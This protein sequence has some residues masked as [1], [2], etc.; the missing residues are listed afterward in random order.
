MFEIKGK[1]TSA[2]I[3]IDSVEEECIT[4]IY[5]FLNHPAFTNPVY[6]MPDTHSGKGS[7]IGFTMK[8]TDYIIPNVVGVDGNCG[9]LAIEIHK[10]NIEQL[11][12]DVLDEL[13]REQIP[14][15]QNVYNVPLLKQVS[16]SKFNYEWFK[17]KC[18]QIGIDLAY[19]ECSLGTLG[20]GNHF[21]EIGVAE[22]TENIWITVHSGSR[23]FG[24][25]LCE[26][27]QSIAEN[28][29]TAPKREFFAEEVKRIKLLSKGKEIEQKI[30]KLK[31]QL[32]VGN[33]PNDLTFLRDKHAQEYLNDMKFVEL[34]A[35]YNREYIIRKISE[36]LQMLPIDV[37]ETVH[38]YISF[39]DD[40]I[41]KGAVASYKGKKLLIPLNMR[42]GILLCEGKSNPDWN[43]SA[44]HGAGRLLSRS[45]AKETLNLEKFKT[46]M[47]GIYS[48]S[49]CYSTLDESPD[50]YK[51][52][53]LIE[54]L[55][56]PTVTII[57]KIKPILN[58]KDK[59]DNKKSWKQIREERKF[60][61]Q[62]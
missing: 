45:K 37:I 34:Y 24:K 20:G 31:E 2:K 15:G 1:Y 35:H 33:T 28:D 59:E 26:Y 46:D 29:I 6:I 56:E 8:K 48:S 51:D 32:F 41:R 19:A 36:I 3:F 10:N 43:F 11:N 12:L 38:N 61:K 27:W 5:K 17:K 54:Q 50:A 47:T 18:K 44:P 55:I 25:K 52:S 4:Q 16:W 53:K 7:V 57:D 30:K 40:I 58:L 13:I 42:D 9:V 14:F 49:V 21:I 39:E 62:L 23:N 22:K 60:K